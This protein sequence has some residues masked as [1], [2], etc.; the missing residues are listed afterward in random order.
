MNSSG[1]R[2]WIGLAV[3][4]LPTLLI[5]LDM[6]VLYLALPHLSA[7]LG[8]DA[9]QQ[10]WIMDIYGFMIAGFLVTMGT[11]GDRIGRRRLLMFGAAAFSVASV[12]AAYSTSAEMLIATRAILGIAGA[13]LMPST[14]AL[15]SNMFASA[16]ERGLAIAVWISCFMGGA[17]IG[18]VIGGALLE[19][20][21]WGSAFLL[22]VPVMVLLLV[23]G[24]FL[25]PE[26]RNE[27]AGRIDLVSVVLSLAA[28]LPV[29]YGLKQLA[30]D[31]WAWPAVAALVAG[32]VVGVFFVRR[33]RV[34]PDPLLDLGMLKNRTF[35]GALGIWLLFG[36]IQ[37]GSFLFVTL[38][39]QVV[40]GLSPMR[41]GLWL[42]P[43]A[44]AMIVGSQ[45]AP[46]LARRFR[47]GYVI[48][49]GL[50]ITA[51]GYLIL[52]GLDASGSL[53]TLVTGMI[54]ALFGVG[55]AAALGTDL[56]V[57][58]V[59]PAKAGSASALSETGA[60]LGISLGVASLGS[61]TTAIYRSEITEAM[62]E[63]VPAGVAEAARENAAGA[64]ASAGELPAAQ[65]A[66]VL[67]AVREAFTSGLTSV[68]V[69][70]AVL[71]AGL[72]V[73]AAI[74]LRDAEPTAAQDAETPEKELV[75]A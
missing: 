1:R 51:V 73:F 4:A 66:E 9:T 6:S 23:T 30:K 38:Y 17:A 74:S 12:L 75:S 55:I 14:L 28:I 43:S 15:I 21:W 34:L 71:F 44:L 3:L 52:T 45:L 59:S 7:D 2:A 5:S 48:S 13:T 63:D 18:P 41:A 37:G 67:D 22:G 62:P 50:G 32:V 54:V 8:A 39:L 29:V 11:L 61:V 24:P 19:N 72:A 49:G 20:F 69:L 25:L 56:I 42:V 31:G 10:L 36:A 40:A 65:A 26:F 33:Q 16:R 68:M 46:L 27:D 47:P 53:P 64:A 58:S 35:S 57:G 60:E 70:G